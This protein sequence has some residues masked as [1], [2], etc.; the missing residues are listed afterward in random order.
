MRRGRVVVGVC[1]C[2]LALVG[3]APSTPDH[4]AWRGQGDQALSEVS[5]NVATARL[6]LQ[7]LRA[8][9]VHGAYTQT[10][11]LDAE[12]NAES[13]TSRF[14]AVQPLPADDDAYQRVGTLLSDAGDLL[15][16][17]RIAVVRRD[18][19]AYP[20]LIR[21]LSSTLQDLGTE[22]ARL[23]GGPPR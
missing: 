16:Q 7:Q 14:T 19:Q 18:D 17:V 9:K 4:A 8:D 11:V 3:C 23:G 12:T 1:L 10:G 21:K 2:V 22:Q 5:S 20:S 13:A 15:A 6:L